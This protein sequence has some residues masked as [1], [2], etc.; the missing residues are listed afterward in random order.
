[1][2]TMHALTTHVRDAAGDAGRAAAAAAPP[3]DQPRPRP[4]GRA[5]AGKVWDGFKWVE[6]ATA[7]A[8]TPSSA[9]PQP[10]PRARP[11]VRRAAVLE[12][13]D[14]EGDEAPTPPTHPTEWEK[15]LDDISD[16]GEESEDEA[17][18]LE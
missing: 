6:A 9:T 4:R 14:S 17:A 2:L 3:S 7:A 8:A 10:Q 1:M 12:S 18:W 13:D 5:P 11:S 15:A 16:A